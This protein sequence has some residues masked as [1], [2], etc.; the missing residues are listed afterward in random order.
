MTEKSREFVFTK[1]AKIALAPY[2]RA[3][4]LLQEGNNAEYESKYADWSGVGIY[5]PG[6]MA[7]CLAD[8]MILASQGRL[9]VELLPSSTH[10]L[11]RFL[12]QPVAGSKVVS[13]YPQQ[14]AIDKHAIS[15]EPLGDAT[16]YKD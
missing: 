11:P 4:Q 14:F 8:D 2:I 3:M 13:G 15:R 10:G 9:T 5:E 1:A 6:T 7:E 16:T 12:V